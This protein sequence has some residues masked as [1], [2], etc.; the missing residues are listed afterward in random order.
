MARHEH[1]AAVRSVGP[2]QVAEG[3]DALGV[4]TVAGFVEDQH[5]RFTQQ[6]GGEAEA[7]AHA[8]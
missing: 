6:G 7:L 3:S 2:E 8:E 5:R 4:E 1:G